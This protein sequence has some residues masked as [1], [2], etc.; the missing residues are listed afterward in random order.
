MSL[1][2]SYLVYCHEKIHIYGKKSLLGLED[3]KLVFRQATKPHGKKCGLNA[4]GKGVR[5]NMILIFPRGGHG[6][7]SN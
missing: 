2:I 3:M 7:K 5:E 1:D 4:F 6:R